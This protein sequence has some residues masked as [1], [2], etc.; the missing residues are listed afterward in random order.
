MHFYMNAHMSCQCPELSLTPPHMHIQCMK[1]LHFKKEDF[2]FILQ[3]IGQ[4]PITALFKSHVSF[5]GNEFL[6]S[7]RRRREPSDIFAGFHHEIHMSNQGC[8]PFT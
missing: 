5:V 1:N 4:P 7:H 8:R 2:Y 6:G 3:L